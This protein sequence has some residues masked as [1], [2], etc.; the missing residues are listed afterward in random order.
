MIAALDSNVFPFLS[1]F[2]LFFFFFY[3][4]QCVIKMEHS[5]LQNKMDVV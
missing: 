1:C 4:P 2:S 3:P 5:E